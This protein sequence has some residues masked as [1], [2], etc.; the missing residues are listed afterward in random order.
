MQ[1]ERIFWAHE[2]KP[3]AIYVRTIRKRPA[4]P[5][6]NRDCFDLA[7]TF[8]LSLF[9]ALVV[10]GTGIDDLEQLSVLF[11]KHLQAQMRKRK[12][13]EADPPDQGSLPPAKK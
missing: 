12:I 2:R 7:G 4:E 11:Q 1:Y 9:V 13:F 5:L 3:C 6:F 10:F 8:S